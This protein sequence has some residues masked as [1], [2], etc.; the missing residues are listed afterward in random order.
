[1]RN[2]NIVPI[3]NYPD[4]GNHLE[5]KIE[6]PFMI[7]KGEDGYFYKDKKGLEKAYGYMKKKDGTYDYKID[8]RWIV[9][10]DGDRWGINQSLKMIFEIQVNKDLDK[11]VDYCFKIYEKSLKLELK[12][13]KKL[14]ADYV[15]C[16]DKNNL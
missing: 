14:K 15:I 9:H 2:Y 11:I 1:M 4:D 5:C 10:I 6:L 3:K 8:N 7:R 13:F 16:N 12:R